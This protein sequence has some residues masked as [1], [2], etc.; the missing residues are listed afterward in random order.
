MAFFFLSKYIDKI[1]LEKSILLLRYPV[2][3][4]LT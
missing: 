1:S 4:T 3:L 2:G